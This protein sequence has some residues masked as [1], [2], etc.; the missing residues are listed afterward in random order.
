MENIME[1]QLFLK[2]PMVAPTAQQYGFTVNDIE[3]LINKMKM[4][5]ESYSYH[6]TDK[7]RE[8]ALKAIFMRVDLDRDEFFKHLETRHVNDEDLIKD[9]GKY[10]ER[11]YK[12][13]LPS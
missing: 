3:L 5:R 6:D 10:N 4:N 12:A 7:S 2:Y 13:L 11:V 9:C 8:V 1:S